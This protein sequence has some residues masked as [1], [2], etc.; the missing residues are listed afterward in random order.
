MYK[1]FNITEKEYGAG[2]TDKQLGNWPSLE[3]VFT[4]KPISQRP[5]S[6]QR[7]E[8]QEAVVALENQKWTRNKLFLG[9]T[10]VHPLKVL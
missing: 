4:V 5:D 7:Q 3:D 6:Q 1:F 10:Q 8:E 9:S 2:P